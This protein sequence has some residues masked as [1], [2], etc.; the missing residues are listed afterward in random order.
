MAA[1][2]DRVGR[3]ARP[4]LRPHDFEPPS[5]RTSAVGFSQPRFYTGRS[6]HWV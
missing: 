2:A 1:V 6:T 4:T 3:R 5:A